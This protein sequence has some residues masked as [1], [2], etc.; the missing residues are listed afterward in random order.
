MRTLR[1]ELFLISG[2]ERLRVVLWI[3]TPYESKSDGAVIWLCDW[4]IE[5][6]LE[7][8][9]ALAGFTGFDA[10]VRNLGAIKE[11]YVFPR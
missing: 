7:K 9:R 8:G 10:L 2:N 1:K 6:I 4:G 5:G 11:M 3:G